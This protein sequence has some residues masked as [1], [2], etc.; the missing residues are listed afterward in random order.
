MININKNSSYN[1]SLT[2]ED[3]DTI[4][5]TYINDNIEIYVN[6]DND[7]FIKVPIYYSNP[8]RWKS[9]QQDGF[10]RDQTS[11]QILLPIIVFK[12]SN[13]EVRT[14]MPIN[15]LDNQLHVRVNESRSK[16]YLNQPIAPKE[17]YSILMPKFVNVTYDFIL[18]TKTIRQNNALVESFLMHDKRYWGNNNYK[19]YTKINNIS[20]E[21]EQNSDVA[22]LVKST[23][24]I[25]ISAFI[26]PSKFK[27]DTV[28]KKQLTPTTISVTTETIS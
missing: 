16:K 23:F 28:I 26:I 20:N 25:I 5:K 18:F 27:N 10:L 3:I 22:R 2:I 7:S 1:I 19:F 4:V 14:D 21:T 17:I 15:D 6:D 13:L 11:Q 24:S 9:I 12:R 8:D